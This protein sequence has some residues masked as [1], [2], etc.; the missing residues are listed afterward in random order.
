MIGKDDWKKLEKEKVTI[1]FNDLLA[2]KEINIS[3][4][5]FKT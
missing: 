4:L 5:S 1:A 3:R 2:K